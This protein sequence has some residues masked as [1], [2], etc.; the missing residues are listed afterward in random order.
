MLTLNDLYICYSQ[1]QRDYFKS[2]GIRYLFTARD[3]RTDKLIWIFER[4][5]AVREVI[6]NW[7]EIKR[8]IPAHVSEEKCDEVR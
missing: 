3:C 6:R 1:V 4:S 8:D 2:Q 7:D 5:D